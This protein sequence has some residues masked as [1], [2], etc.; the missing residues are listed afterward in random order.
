MPRGPPLSDIEKG[1]ILALHH[2]LM[3]LRDISKELGRSVG[4]IQRFLK[5]PSRTSRA[6]ALVTGQKLTVREEKAMIRKASTG[7]F[8]AQDQKKD[9]GLPV[10]VRRIQQILSA[11]LH[12]KYKK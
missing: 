12:L 4:A 1:Q 5:N 2:Q 9:L 3:S 8:S 10:E 11:T 7:N 6:Y